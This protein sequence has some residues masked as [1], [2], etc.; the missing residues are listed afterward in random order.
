MGALEQRKQKIAE[1]AEPF[2]D[3]GET[4]HE[5][6]MG[7]TRVPAWATMVAGMLAKVHA[8]AATDK[9]V[10]A[11]RVGSATS[12]KE[13]AVK[14]PLKAGSVS[15]NGSKLKVGELELN[16]L[17]GAKEDAQRLVEFVNQAGRS[18]SPSRSSPSAP[19]RSLAVVATT[20]SVTRPRRSSAGR[21]RRG[22]PVP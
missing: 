16:V 3:G 7:Q 6:A 11:F 10:Y 12:V 21:E 14:E 17:I 22:C 5:M 4:I 18:A 15:L 19:A 13:I 1:N 2:L 9:N 20:R 8:A